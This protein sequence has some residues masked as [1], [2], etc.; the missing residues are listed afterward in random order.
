[1]KPHRAERPDIPGMTDHYKRQNRECAAVILKNPTAY[2]KGSALE[3][4]ARL[5][6]GEAKA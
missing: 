3:K 1:M 4:W 2:P 6:L 5:V